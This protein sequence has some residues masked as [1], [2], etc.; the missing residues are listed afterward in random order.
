MGNIETIDDTVTMTTDDD[1]VEEEEEI[2]EEQEPQKRETKD[3]KDGWVMRYTHLFMV[4]L[5]LDITTIS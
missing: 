4:R 3:K 1:D 5:Y 2:N